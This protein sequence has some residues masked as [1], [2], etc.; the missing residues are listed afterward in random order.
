MRQQAGLQAGEE[1]E[2]VAPFREVQRR[3]LD[4]VLAHQDHCPTT[5]NWKNVSG[6]VKIPIHWD[7]MTVPCW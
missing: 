3:S 5:V 1:L 7:G 6:K 2:E 4:A